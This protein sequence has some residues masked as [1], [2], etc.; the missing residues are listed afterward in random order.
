M[1]KLGLIGGTGPKSIIEY[2]RKHVSS[3]TTYL[4]SIKMIDCLAT[5]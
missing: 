3:S 2:Y 4:L 5:I 1:K